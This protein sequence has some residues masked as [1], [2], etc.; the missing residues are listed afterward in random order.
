MTIDKKVIGYKNPNLQKEQKKKKAI[1]LTIALFKNSC[2]GVNVLLLRRV[3][4]RR[5]HHRED[6]QVLVQPRLYRG[7]CS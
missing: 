5:D 1:G 6:L 7:P 2:E 4:L 3:L